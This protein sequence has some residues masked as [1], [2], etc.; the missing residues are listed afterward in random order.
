M[1]KYPC[2]LLLV[3]VMSASS[4]LAQSKDTAPLVDKGPPVTTLIAVLTT[5]LESRSGSCGPGVCTK[6]YY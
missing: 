4:F 6:N 2:Q 5:S 3:L 1:I